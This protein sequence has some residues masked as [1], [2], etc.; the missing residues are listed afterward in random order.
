MLRI[1]LITV[2]AAALLTIAGCSPTGTS[3]RQLHEQ[4]SGQSVELRT[5]DP[6]EIILDGN[7]TTG[8]TWEQSEGNGAVLKL[9]GE[10]SYT[11]ESNLVGAGGT[12][13]F[14]FA[15]VAPG[16]TRA[17][18]RRRASSRGRLGGADERQVVVALLVVQAQRRPE[19]H[20]GQAGGMHPAH[21]LGRDE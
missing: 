11:S 12:Y 14:R 9:A 16:E 10:P 3:T 1:T 19:R 2:V 13:M 17:S 5:G 21:L 8:Y 6:L 7:P 4:D 20:M 15:A 18:H